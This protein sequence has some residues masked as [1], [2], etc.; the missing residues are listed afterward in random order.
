MLCEKKESLIRK[1]LLR[2]QQPRVFMSNVHKLIDLLVNSKTTTENI[3]KSVDK[4]I[5]DY[6][7][8][9]YQLEAQLPAM[10]EQDRFLYERF[11]NWWM[12]DVRPLAKSFKRYVRWEAFGR[13]GT[14]DCMCQYTDGRVE[15]FL[16]R[17]K[18]FEQVSARSRKNPMEFDM[19]A[20]GALYFL[21][22]NGCEKADVT[23]IFLEG[24]LDAPSFSVEDGKPQSKANVMRYRYPTFRNANGTLNPDKLK[25]GFQEAL[26][27]QEK[28]TEQPY[29][30][31]CAL[32]DLCKVKPFSEEYLQSTLVEAQSASS[33]YSLPDFT[34]K[35]GCRT[36]RRSG[37]SFLRSGQWKDCCT[38]WKNIATA[39]KRRV[40]DLYCVGNVHQQGSRRVKRAHY[41]LSAG[42][43]TAADHQH[44]K[45]AGI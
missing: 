29:C 3:M 45:C 39:S 25:Q 26:T 32:Y 12:R 17:R 44:I 28:D 42:R 15:A 23:L 34:S 4:W 35:A 14:I 38:G 43:R 1:G 13:K 18:N 5:A 11:V 7:P 8:A 2:N 21:A 41:R 33:K 10:Q 36:D 22:T 40:T 31:E 19:D 24:R 20:I 27:A 37:Q 6:D 16:I 30:A 9:W